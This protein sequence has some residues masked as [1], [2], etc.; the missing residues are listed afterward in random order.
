MFENQAIEVLSE[1]HLEFGTMDTD[2]FQIDSEGDLFY[3]I[4]DGVIEV[5]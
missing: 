2:V 4:L 5:W 1:M 3:L